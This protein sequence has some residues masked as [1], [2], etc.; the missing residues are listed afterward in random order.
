MTMEETLPD[1]QPTETPKNNQSAVPEKP[2]RR[3]IP[4]LSR[5]KLL[6][7]AGVAVLVL[8]GAIVLFALR[9]NKSASTTVS[10]ASTP[11][12][13]TDNAKSLFGTMLAYNVNDGLMGSGTADELQKG[14]SVFK[15]D[16]IALEKYLTSLQQLYENRD[17]LVKETKFSL[18]REIA[19]L[20]TWNVIEPEKG[21]FDWSLTDLAAQHARNAQ[22]KISAVIQPFTSWDQKNTQVKSFC[23][24]LDFAWYD[25]KAGPPNDWSEYQKFLEITVK[26]YKDVV[27]AWEIGNEYDGQCGGYQNNPDGYLKLLRISYETIKGI[28][29]SARILNGGALEF[30]DNSVRNFWTKFF[31]LGGGNYFDAFNFHYNE[32][33][34]GVTNDP[35]AFLEVLS[36]YNN[37][38]KNQNLAKPLWLTEFGTYSGTPQAAPGGPL[39]SAPG[40]SAPTFPTQSQELQAG[41][42]FRYSILALANNTERIIIDFIGSDNQNIGGSAIYN[43]QNQSRSFLKTLQTIAAKIQG[44]SKVEKIADSQYKFTVDGKTIYALW[45]GTLPSEISG[46][47]KVTD[48]KGR[49]EI[50]DATR[51]KLNADQPIFVDLQN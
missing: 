44:F 37:L 47:V 33:R 34:N 51:I 41:W 26:R 6:I 21:N 13:T 48:M 31:Q 29:P 8:A 22:I 25:Y 3:R 12:N 40:G 46:K 39:G 11:F 2:V 5:K 36:F 10:S 45:S 9:G 4:I 50:M 7:I 19:G 38:I 17:G 18:D 23:K 49:G 1:D 27:L 20:Y 43:T 28:D 35:S 14:W 32:G 16:P 24:A 15:N 30:S 42:Y